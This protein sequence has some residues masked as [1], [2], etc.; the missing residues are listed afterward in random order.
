MKAGAD[1]HAIEV[2]YNRPV[3]PI[4]NGDLLIGGLRQRRPRVY[5]NGREIACD[6]IFNQQNHI[7]LTLGN[8]DHTTPLTIDPVIEYSTYLGGNGEDFANGI[9]L[10]GNNS[11]YI[12]GSLESPAYPSLDPFQQASG[13]SK[14]ITWS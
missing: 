14:D 10:D 9:A 5:Q 13:T 3:Q 11:A 8:Y 2:S 1:P 6:Y 7:Q 12:V 4:S